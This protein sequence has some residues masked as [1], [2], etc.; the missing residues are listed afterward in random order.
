MANKLQNV[1]ENEYYVIKSLSMMNYLVR[2]GFDVLKVGDNEFYPN[3][4][5]FLFADS[6][7]LRRCMESFRRG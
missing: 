5:V 7:E 3:L 6:L 1:K 2:N 4:K